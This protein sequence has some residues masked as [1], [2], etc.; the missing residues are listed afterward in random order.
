MVLGIIIQNRLIVVMAHDRTIINWLAPIDW[1]SQLKWAGYWLISLKCN[2]TLHRLWCILLRS[3]TK[4]SWSFSLHFVLKG[5]VWQVVIQP[6]PPPPPRPRPRMAII[7]QI[8]QN[9][10]ANNLSF[11]IVDDPHHHQWQDVR[12]IVLRVQCIRYKWQITINLSYIYIYICIDLSLP[13]SVEPWKSTPNWNVY[14][15]NEPMKFGRSFP[16][17]AGL[18]L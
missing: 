8:M 4:T 15:T 12:W 7:R 14:S 17:S 10:V 3:E 5:A 16:N 2:E 6:Q 18:T 11:M 9:W 13:L 1:S